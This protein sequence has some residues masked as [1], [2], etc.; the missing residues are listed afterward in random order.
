[1]GDDSEWE[2]SYIHFE[3][4]NNFSLFCADPPSSSS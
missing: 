3:L 2:K 4:E 1:M